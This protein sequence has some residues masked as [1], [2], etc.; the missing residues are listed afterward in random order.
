MEYYQLNTSR[1][2]KQNISQIVQQP[3]L[4][5]TFFINNMKLR[6]L[7][8]FEI[9]YSISLLNQTIKKRL[10]YYLEY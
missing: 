6:T 8:L 1:Q 4:G 2:Q 5:Q 10:Q 7:T 9:T 3:F